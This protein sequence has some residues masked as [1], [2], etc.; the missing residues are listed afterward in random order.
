LARLRSCD[1]IQY[2]E[3]AEGHCNKMLPPSATLAPRVLDGTFCNSKA[4]A[5]PI[6]MRSQLGWNSR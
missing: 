5:R 2:V 4:N 6:Y 3:H 1:G